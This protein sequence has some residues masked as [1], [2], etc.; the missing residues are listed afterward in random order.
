MA[1]ID[2]NAVMDAIG[3]RLATIS[4]L[5][6][7]DYP[8]DTVNPP[9]AVVGLPTEVIYDISKARG[10]D[11][12]TIPVFVLVGSPFSRAARDAL[13]PYLA[14]SGAQSVK[15]AIEADETL[16]G[17]CSALRVTGVRTDGSGITVNGIQYMGAILEV[18][19]WS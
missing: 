12:A 6:V 9:A 13:V 15:T 8:A 3:V 11:M 14:G 17:A 2:V 19:V 1:P 18:E 16:S 7:F 4:G 10:F 5:R